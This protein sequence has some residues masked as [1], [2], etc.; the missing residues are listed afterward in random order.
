MNKLNPTLWRTCRVLSGATR[1]RL[2]RRIID[3]PGQNVSQLAEAEKIGVSGASQELR[4]LQ[5]RGLLKRT[6]Q[7]ASVVYRAFPDPQVASA[8]PLLKTLDALFAS[9]KTDEDEIAG[10][11]KGLAHERRIAIA[12]ALLKGPKTDEQLCNMARIPRGTLK[13]HLKAMKNAG[14]VRKDGKHH[15]LPPSSHPFVQALM[16]LLRTA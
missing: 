5:S 1:L 15:V 7:G 11:A 4:R 12:C 16:K 14:M 8:S 2:L 6:S 10:I 13:W 3:R 9:G